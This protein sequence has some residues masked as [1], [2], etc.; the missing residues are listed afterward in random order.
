MDS[1]TLVDSFTNEGARLLR[2]L[3]ASRVSVPVAFWMK[4]VDSER[5]VL[6]LGRKGVNTFGARSFLLKLHALLIREKIKIPPLDIVVSDLRDEKIKLIV[7]YLANSEFDSPVSLSG[8]FH[9]GKL[10]PECIVYRTSTP[11]LSEEAI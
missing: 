5:W 11:T 3:D 7:N 10:I 4:N 9:G 2:A 6:V 8:S 1:T